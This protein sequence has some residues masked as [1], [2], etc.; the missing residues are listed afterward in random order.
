M[1]TDGARDWTLVGAREPYFGVV[2]AP[3]F[4]AAALDGRAIEEFYASGQADIDRA[5][6]WCVED[7]GAAPEG[8]RA[9][10]IGAGLGR[11]TLA[12]ARHAREVVGFDPA[13]T[14]LEKA[15]AR[16]AE[17]GATNAAFVG[18]LPEGPFDWISS[19]IVFQHIPP[20]DGL[21]LLE[22]ALAGAAPR[23][24]LTLHIAAWTDARV[25]PSRTLVSRLAS[26]LLRARARAGAAP[27]ETLI[28]MHAY[29]LSDVMARLVAAGFPRATFRHVD[30]DGHHGVWIIARR[31]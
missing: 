11:L 7:L 3:R 14:M 4:R 9:L 8:G 25:A 22:R 1:S 23:A 24:F 26:A 20:A 16:A 10:D 29:N 13:P 27:V 21:V 6:A 15:R 2:S 31:A 30:H 19:Y 17:T 18:A 28:R 5:R 12:M